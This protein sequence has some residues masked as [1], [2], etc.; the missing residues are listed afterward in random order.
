MGVG[1]GEVL[2]GELL[3]DAARFGQFARVGRSH[4]EGGQGL[5][6]GEAWR[7]RNQPWPSAITRAEVFKA[8]GPSTGCHGRDFPGAWGDMG[9]E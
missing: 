2:V 7:R 3:H 6:E 8:M 1:Q 4:V 5:D 9:P